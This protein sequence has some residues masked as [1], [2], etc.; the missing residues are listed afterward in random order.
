MVLNGIAGRPQRGPSGNL[1]M[2]GPGTYKSWSWQGSLEAHVQVLGSRGTARAWG[3]A[4]LGVEVG[5]LGILGHIIH[6]RS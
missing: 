3:S 5:D 6:R 1:G 2:L 4:F